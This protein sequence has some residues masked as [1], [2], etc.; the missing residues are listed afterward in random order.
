MRY[1]IYKHYNSDGLVI[2]CGK[3]IRMN[4]RQKEHLNNSVWRNDIN[5]ITFCEVENKTIMD[6]YEIYLINILNP[7]YNTKDKHGD[8]LECINFKDYEFIDYNIDLD[9]LRRNVKIKP[10]PIDLSYDYYGKYVCMTNLANID[11]IVEYDKSKLMK[12]FNMSTERALEIFVKSLE[13]HNMLKKNRKSL[14]LK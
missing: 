11:G 9:N 3:T 7:K 14:N 12:F 8:T 13:Q 5:K 1:N 4:S 10:K 2:Y 6:L